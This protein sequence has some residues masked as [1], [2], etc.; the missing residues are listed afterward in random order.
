MTERIDHVAEAV[1]F[2]GATVID[3]YG[4]DDRK[5]AIAQVHATLALVEQQRIANVIALGEHWQSTG[6]DFADSVAPV[7]RDDIKAA[8]GLD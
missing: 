5:A 7:R 6:Y 4:D 8:L 3:T 1:N 2:L